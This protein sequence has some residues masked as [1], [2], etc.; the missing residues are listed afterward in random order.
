[1]FEHLNEYCV[2]EIRNGYA[3]KEGYFICLH[4]G[5][6]FKK[7]EI[8]KMNGAYYEAFLAVKMHLKID[9]PAYFN[10]LLD[11]TSH[12]LTEKQVELL[13]YM[14]Q[15][16]KDSEIAKKTNVAASTI[17]HQRFMFKEKAKQAK[18]YLA[19]IEAALA[20]LDEMD[21]IE[22][23]EGAKMVDERFCVSDKEEAKV[24]ETMFDSFEPLKLKQFPA[25][26]KKKIIVLRKIASKFVKG[27]E[28]SETEVNEILKAIYDDYVSIRRALIEYG[29]MDRDKACTKYWKR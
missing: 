16:V 22:I 20:D 4:C 9:H 28:Y 17:R 13:K 14:K 5:K 3:E 27:Q 18:L 26:D 12:G 19:I 6:K 10:D 21:S 25:K 11:F 29:F 7:G 23:H 1:M 2:E 15:G 24:L 8:F